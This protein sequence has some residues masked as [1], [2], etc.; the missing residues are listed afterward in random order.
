MMSVRRDADAQCRQPLWHAERGI[1]QIELDGARHT[2]RLRLQRIYQ[3]RPQYEELVELDERERERLLVIAHPLLLEPEPVDSLAVGTPRASERDDDVGALT[4][5]DSGWVNLRYRRIGQ[6]QGWCYPMT[7]TI[8]LWECYLHSATDEHLAQRL[9]PALAVVWDGFE[10][11]L[12]EQLPGAT[13]IV[14]P[15][16]ELLYA[17]EPWQQFLVARGYRRLSADVF[18]RALQTTPVPSATL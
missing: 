17:P 16:R 3:L 9:D 15:A 12:R 7:R 18:G 4:R 13:R 8:V 6:A 10:R 11:V 1:G 2:V 14:T 5:P